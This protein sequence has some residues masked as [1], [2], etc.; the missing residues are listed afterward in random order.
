VL[1]PLRPDDH[2]RVR[3]FLL[4]LGAPIVAE[5]AS[6]LREDPALAHLVLAGGD[7]SA[8]HPSFDAVLRIGGVP[9]LRRWRD[10]DRDTVPVCS[11]SRV[12]LAGLAR[13]EVVVGSPGA[14]LGDLTPPARPNDAALAAATERDIQIGALLHAEPTSEPG[15]L[16]ALS[17][18]IPDDT[19]LFLGNSLP[20]REWDLAAGRAP[21]G[22]TV[23]ASRGANG[24]EG[25][26]STFLGMCAGERDHWALIGDLTA[27]YDLSAPWI[28]PRL[29]GVGSIR[30]V[31]VNNG[32]GQIF[33]RLFKNPSFVNA[34]DRTFKYWAR[35][36][37][38][39]YAAWT[40]IPPVLPSLGAL[41]SPAVIEL[42]PDPNATARFWAAF[43]ALS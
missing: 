23:G 31:V 35:M 24:I 16:R 8:R 43:D 34:H 26:V 15:M 30:I 12:P 17:R 2:E 7:R 25:Q 29:A 33:S 32:G 36:W 28:L 22:W 40:E 21:R 27:L 20:I 18:I 9:T 39:F 1:G 5:P 6:G 19:H 38:L 3:G 10:L 14:M 41:P 42:Q 13:G 37:G 4:R 11:A